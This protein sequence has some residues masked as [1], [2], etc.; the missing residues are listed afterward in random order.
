MGDQQIGPANILE[1]RKNSDI[2][3]P[4]SGCGQVVR[5][6]LPKLTFTGSNPVTRSASLTAKTSPNR[7]G[8][9]VSGSAGGQAGSN[10]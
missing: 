9:L 3:S 7:G 6:Q 8:L 10:R 4:L 5:H 1:D 2:I